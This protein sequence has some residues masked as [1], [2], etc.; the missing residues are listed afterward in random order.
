MKHE[1]G[2][3][4]TFPMMQKSLWVCGRLVAKLHT[5]RAEFDVLTRSCQDVHLSWMFFNGQRSTAGKEDANAMLALGANDFHTSE[6]E[7]EQDASTNQTC[8]VSGTFSAPRPKTRAN[9]T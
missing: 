4:P 5:F 6:S 3:Q 1:F 9:G 8:N 2:Q 7:V